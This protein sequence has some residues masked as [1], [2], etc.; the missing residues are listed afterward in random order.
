MPK[1]II[2][3]RNGAEHEIE[4]VAGRSVMEN[5]RDAGIDELQALCGGSCA[6]ATCHVH[7][8]PASTGQVPAMDEDENDLLEGSG[9]RT[10]TSRLS[11]QIRLTP[12]MSGLRLTIAPEE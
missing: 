3:T 12:A 10:E 6:C 9:H 11:C 5:I 2:V 1:L 7:L 8:D 4:G